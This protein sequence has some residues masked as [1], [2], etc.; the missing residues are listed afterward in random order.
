MRKLRCTPLLAAVAIGGAFAP[1]A[2]ADSVAVDQANSYIVT[3]DS[4]DPDAVAAEHGR[5]HGADV[6]HVQTRAARVRGTHVHVGGP[7]G[8]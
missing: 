6:D 8:G 1:A 5:R 2:V 3:L 7:T 4:G